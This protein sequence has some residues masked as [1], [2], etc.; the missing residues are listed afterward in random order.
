MIVETHFASHKSQILAVCCHAARN[1]LQPLVLAKQL[2]GR[3][4]LKHLWWRIID[5]ASPV[6]LEHVLTEVLEKLLQTIRPTLL[7]CC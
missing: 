3:Y 5:I 4:S 6:V 7:G 1:I 2:I